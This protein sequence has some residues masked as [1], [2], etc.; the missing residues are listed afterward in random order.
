[1]GRFTPGFDIKSGNPIGRDG[2]IVSC[3]R[4]SDCYNRCPS[5]PLT[6][7]RYQCQTTYAFALA[8]ISMLQI[9]DS[10]CYCRRYSLYDVPI[11]GK[12]GEISLVDLDRG[13]GKVFDPEPSEQAITGELGI[14][15]DVDSSYNQGC[16]DQIFS[17]VVDGAI[18]C[19]DRQISQWLCGLELDISDGDMSTAAIKGSF[20]YIPPRVLVKKGEDL[21]GDGQASPEITCSDPID[22][23]TKCKYL[24]RTSLHG[25]GAP[26]A[27]ALCKPCP[28]TKPNSTPTQTPY[29][30]HVVYLL[31]FCLQVTST[32]QTIS[33]LPLRHWWML[34][35]SMSSP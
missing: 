14:C 16:P 26:P 15:V 35:G 20:L 31:Q 30:T 11:T 33:C 25:A 1:M 13:S 28:Q 21:N 18:G 34:S 10:W 22:C 2:Y 19:F 12:D 4:N 24:E 32:A 6:G 5:H 3:K 9:V 27:C 17:S 23:R 8:L 29:T 7:D